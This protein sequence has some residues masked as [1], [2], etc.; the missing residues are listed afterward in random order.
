[1][2]DH[3]EALSGYVEKIK[4][5]RE[6]ILTNIVLLGQIPAPT[7]FEEN[8]A[9][10]FLERLSEF[11]TDECSLDQYGNAIGI[12]RGTADTKPPIFIIAHLDTLFCEDIVYNFTVNEGHI[13][14]PGLC[15]NSLSVGILASLPE[16]FQALNL[17]FESD[18]VLAGV[19]HTLGNGN[20]QG[21]RHLL[22]IW[23]TPIRGAVCLESHDL[24]RL[25]FFSDGMLRCDILGTPIKALPPQYTHNAIQIINEV[26]NRVL[27]LQLPIRPKSKIVLGKISG[28]ADYGKNAPEA[29]LGFEIRSDSDQMVKSI[30][31]DIKDIV[32]NISHEYAVELAL[33]IVSNLDACRL[34]YNHPL[35]K[36]AA[37]VMK[38]LNVHPFSQP[39]ES[40][41]S[42]FLSRDIPSITIGL[43]RGEDYYSANCKMKIEPLFTGIAQLVGVVMAIDKGV[44][45]E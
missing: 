25:N 9:Q 34:K 6:I 23:P 3:L 2:E 45:D 31:N 43:T 26:I 10:T 35:V 30:Y 32:D 4:T 40:A 44:C 12:I 8:R 24:G 5:I 38:K 27:E 29:R 7:F 22:K 41:C 14:G 20:L 21:P 18:I 15:D 42:I 39:S 17:R 19:I 33:S 11:Q 13:Q 37:A 28:G 36:S 1:M 16:I